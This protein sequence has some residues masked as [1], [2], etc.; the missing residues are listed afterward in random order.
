MYSLWVCFTC[1]LELLALDNKRDEEG[2]LDKDK[3]QFLKRV[4]KLAISLPWYFVKEV[5]VE[6]THG[7]VPHARG[8]ITEPEKETA[9][10]MGKQQSSAVQFSK[11]SFRQPP[12]SPPRN[13]SPPP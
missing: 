12:S 13:Q 1:K 7:T 5:F 6:A 11:L 4:R 2:D 3:E 10:G 9:E 8:N